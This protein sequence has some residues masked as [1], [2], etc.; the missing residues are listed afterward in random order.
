MGIQFSFECRFRICPSY[1][2]SRDNG[3]FLKRCSMIAKNSKFWALWLLKVTI[4]TGAKI[5]LKKFPNHF[6]TSFRTLFP[7]FFYLR[8]IGAE[9]DGGCSPPPPHVGDGKYGM[10]VGHG[11]KGGNAKGQ[12][13]IVSLSKYYVGEPKVLIFQRIRKRRWFCLDNFTM[14]RACYWRRRFIFNMHLFLFIYIT[15]VQ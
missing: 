3:G 7:V 8:P 4:L 1:N 9:I 10:P 2:S 11:L 12:E 13:K 15:N 6:L 14:L 5:W